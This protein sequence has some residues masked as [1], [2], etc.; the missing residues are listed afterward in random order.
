MHPLIADFPEISLHDL[1]IPLAKQFVRYVSQFGF[2]TAK[3]LGARQFGIEREIVLIDVATC[4]GQRP[5]YSFNRREVLGVLFSKTEAPRVLSMRTDFPDTPHQNWSA[6]GQPFSPC[7]DNRSWEVARLT[8]TSSELLQRIVQWFQQ[9]SKGEL[10]GSDQP[11]DP[12]L[13]DCGPTLILPEDI[14]SLSEDQCNVLLYGRAIRS[15]GEEKFLLVHF[16]IEMSQSVNEQGR[17]PG[18]FLCL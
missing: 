3:F 13:L 14:F 15:E 9:A 1:S 17:F 5:V 12:N 18:F 4:C 10:H 8:Y 2:D 16:S 6:E 11:L 7:I